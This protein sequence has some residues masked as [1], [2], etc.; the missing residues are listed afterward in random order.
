MDI[1]IDQ[2]ISELSKIDIATSNILSET[3]SE[4]SKYEKL[5]KEKISEFDEKLEKNIKNELDMYENKLLAEN[6]SAI[7]K[8]KSETE[9]ELAAIDEAYNKNHK[10]WADEIF[11]SIIKERS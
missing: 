7:K 1:Q 11:N 3:D 9:N 8:I 5:I 6:T 4:K 10:K 2:I